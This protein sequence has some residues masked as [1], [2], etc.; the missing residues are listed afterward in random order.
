MTYYINEV[1]AKR[2]VYGQHF[3]PHDA[4]AR[5]LQTGKSRV[6]AM[7]EYNL[8]PEVLPA[9]SVADG[10]HAVRQMLP[11]C[12]ID[13]NKCQPGIDALSQYRREWDDKNKVYKNKPLHDWTSHDADAIRIMAMS[14][15]LVGANNKIP[16]IQYEIADTYTGY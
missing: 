7:E 11:R 1:Q 3:L 16:E 12:W 4:K 9:T 5:E 2:Y 8:T 15:N 10:I 13:K 14:L 6:D